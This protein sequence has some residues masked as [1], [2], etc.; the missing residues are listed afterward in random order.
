MK[1]VTDF[2][3]LAWKG[4]AK[5]QLEE[6]T[7][8]LFQ[9]WRLNELPFSLI[10]GKTVLDAGCGSGRYS[11]ALLQLGAGKVV[12]VDAERPAFKAKGFVFR[13][14]SVLNLP[15][16]D[17]SFDFVF[18]NGVLHHTKYWKR[19][20]KEVCRVTSHGGWLWLLVAGKSRHWA[21]ADRI[22]KKV[23]SADAEAF[24]NY[25]LLRGWPPNKIF[26]LLD[27]FFTPHRDYISKSEVGHELWRNGFTRIGF[28]EKDVEES[29]GMNLRFVAQKVGG[30]V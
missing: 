19:G 16:E 23:N 17:D 21:L 18:C 30:D 11:H 8:L 10:E 1:K 22:R 3:D 7:W 13:K 28:L 9:R 25:L 12:G 20:L 24:K 15:F 14:G 27:T 6:A 2:Y 4:F 5:Q 26:F 29:H